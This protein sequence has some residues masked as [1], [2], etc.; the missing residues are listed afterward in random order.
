[1]DVGEIVVRTIQY[2]LLISSAVEVNNVC[3]KIAFG[4]TIR[5][6]N[7]TYKRTKCTL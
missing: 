7:G 2:H 1:M 3:G 5:C 4:K 6:S